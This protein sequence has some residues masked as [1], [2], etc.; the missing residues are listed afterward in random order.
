MVI[1]EADFLTGREEW[2]AAYD[3]T[4]RRVSSPSP[5]G[6]VPDRPLHIKGERAWFRWSDEPF[7]DRA[8]KGGRADSRLTLTD[9]RIAARPAA[10]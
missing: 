4:G 2:E 6:P 9:Q 7:D 1:D 5:D 10:H 8:G 3:E